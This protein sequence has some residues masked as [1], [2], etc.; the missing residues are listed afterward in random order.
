M[1]SPRLL[2]SYQSFS[3]GEYLELKIW[4]AARATSAAPTFFKR[5][6][7]GPPGAQE[8][9]L[10]GGVGNNNPIRL[11]MEETPRAFDDQRAVAC[12]ISIGTGSTNITEFKE[13][14][15]FQ[16]VVPIKLIEVLKEIATDC[17]R[18][19]KEVARRFVSTPGTY[20]RF[21]VEHGLER[22]PMESYDELGN[23]K[24]KTINYL[25]GD[26]IAHSVDEAVLALCNLSDRIKASEL[27][28]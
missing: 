13:P 9:F 2:Q 18:V 22:I 27:C 23:I 14:G 6:K 11:L 16:K 25:Q 26:K 8:E 17:E 19:E 4:E 28:T 10:D 12:I 20:F 7:I 24:S 1:N 3:A 5:M 21:N 15:L